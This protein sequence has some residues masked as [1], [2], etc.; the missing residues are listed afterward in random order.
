MNKRT[1]LIWIITPLALMWD[2]TFWCIKKI[3]EGSVWF[4][5]FGKEKIDNLLN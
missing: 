5:E 1:V 3:Y 2:A 4:D